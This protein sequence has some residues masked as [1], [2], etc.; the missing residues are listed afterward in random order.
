MK[1]LVALIFLAMMFLP[2]IFMNQEEGKI[3]ESE[4]RVLAS[5]PELR[6][7]TGELQ[8]DRNQWE[9]Y[10]NDNIGFRDLAIA[11]NG[12]FVYE[13]LD[14]SP[15]SKVQ[16]GVDEWLFYI[17]NNNVEIAYGNYLLSEDM[18]ADLAKNQVAI[19]ESLS[20]QGIDYALV[21]PP[22]KVSI[23]PENL[24]ENL[25]VI[26]SPVDIVAEYLETH[27]QVPVI[28][29]KEDLL[30]AKGQGDLYYPTDTHW[31]DRGMRVAAE[32]MIE[33]LENLGFIEKTKENLQYIEYEIDFMGDLTEMLPNHSFM[34]S[35]E[36][37]ELLVKD[38][39]AVP[40]ETEELEQQLEARFF[41]EYKSFE[42][43]E[44]ENG[45]L[46]IY[47]DSMLGNGNIA[48]YL[49]ESFSKLDLAKIYD[50]WQDQIFLEDILEINPDIVLF[51]LTERSLDQLGMP[52]LDE[53]F[54]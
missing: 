21:L 32:S 22:S 35:I 17:P 38:G 23:Y 52:L 6:S 34:G 31:N 42:N 25:S 50:N 27:T 12:L 28:R 7:E 51:S 36:E 53:S 39:K 1:Y 3:S 15:S 48:S 26:I 47:G 54:Y 33:D 8:L 9:A 40:V 10:V 30:A 11:G 5:M 24:V 2:L 19:F 41:T 29:L 45:T 13:V 37:V 18:L 43:S 49:A 20:E 14:K 4:N 46:L 16:L 44:V